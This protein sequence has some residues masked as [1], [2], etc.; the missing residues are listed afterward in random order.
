M[1]TCHAGVSLAALLTS[2]RVLAA[3]GW[4]S[5]HAGLASTQSAGPPW[6]ASCNLRESTNPSPLA[7]PITAHAAP[8]RSA[9]SSAQARSSALAAST[10]TLADSSARVRGWACSARGL[11]QQSRPIQR[12]SPPACP[13][14]GPDFSLPS[15]TQQA[16]WIMSDTGAS[17]G[18]ARAAPPA[19]CTPSSSCTAPHA[20]PPERASNM[21]R[22]VA[23]PW[24][25]LARCQA[26]WAARAGGPQAASCC[27][28]WSRASLASVRILI[29][30]IS[31]QIPI[32]RQK[33][34]TIA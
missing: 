31:K 7:S 8:L 22:P 20:S 18:L 21:G 24:T 2:Q 3:E 9:T 1:R 30:Y 17:Q 32:K 33:K 19:G 11:G 10:Y 14:T 29:G 13:P 16:R 15:C 23:M 12:T 34:K 26:P 25:P 27:L 28:S 5:S 4:C 6:A